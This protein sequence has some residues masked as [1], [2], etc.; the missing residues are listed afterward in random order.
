[1][2]AR[3]GSAIVAIGAFAAISNV[4]S[5]AYAQ[6][7]APQ[8]VSPTTPYPTTTPYRQPLGEQR[9]EFVRPNPV[10]LTTGALTL[11]GG[12]VP[13]FIV[14]AGSDHDGDDWLFAPVIGPWMDLATRG[15]G[16]D[17]VTA[18]CGTTSFDRAALIGSGVIQ[19]I[20][21]AQL[22]AAFTL[23][24]KRL[25]TPQASSNKPTVRIAPTSFGRGGQGIVAFGTF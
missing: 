14:A 5:G 11:L 24:Q 18:A 3:L 23:P 21:A 17:E 19:A 6:N 7:A 13:G 4:S 8:P 10:F 1:M 16:D 22:V 15:C 2:K 12:Y 9:T 20:G 25:S